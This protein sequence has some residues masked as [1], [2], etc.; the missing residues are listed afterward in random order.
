MSVAKRS[1]TIAGHRTSLSLEEPFWIALQEIAAQKQ[2][3]VAAL[4]QE[5][6]KSRGAGLNLSAALRVFVLNHYKAASRG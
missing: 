1:V 2:R 5:V 3:P 6:D 4:I